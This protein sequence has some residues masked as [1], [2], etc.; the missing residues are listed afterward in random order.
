MPSLPVKMKILLK[1][2]KNSWKT[3]YRLF[4]FALFHMKT[5][6]SLK[7]F[8]TDCRKTASDKLLLDKAF[9]IA[10]NPKYDR[11]QLRLASMVYKFFNKK[12]SGANTSVTCVQPET[13]AGGAARSEIMSNR[14][15][16]EELHKSVVSK[17][18]K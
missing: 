16:A 11:Y 12:S 10:K 5:R 8:V 15:L 18:E 4:H 3:E 7:Y 13:L 17:L 6:V 9:N 2:V 1:L 14:T